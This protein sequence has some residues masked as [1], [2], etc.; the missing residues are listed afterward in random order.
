MLELILYLLV[1]GVALTVLSY[2][3]IFFIAG[4]AYGYWG[5]SIAMA[6][7][8]WLILLA[9]MLIGFVC[10][11]KNAIKAVKILYGKGGES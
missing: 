6:P 11:V 7:V 1:I 4:I 2:A 5:L 9:G 8:V 3:S 10:A